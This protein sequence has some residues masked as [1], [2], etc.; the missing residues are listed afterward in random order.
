MKPE[1]GQ[2]AKHIEG[3][4][5]FKGYSLTS[6][7]LFFLIEVKNTYREILDPEFTKLYKFKVNNYHMKNYM[8]T[9]IVD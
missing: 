4:R 1:T 5:K 9:S 7:T 3:R 2:G 8:Q 6:T